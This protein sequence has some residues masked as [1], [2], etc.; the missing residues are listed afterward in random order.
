MASAAKTKMV[1]IGIMMAIL[2]VGIAS[3]TPAQEVCVDKT[4]EVPG[5]NTCICS[6]N[7][8]CAGMCILQDEVDVKTCFVDCVLKNDCQC[9]PKDH[10]AEKKTD[11]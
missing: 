8:A 4:Y 11:G 2:F 5:D 1:A 3:A 10:G 7:C 6:K 9:P